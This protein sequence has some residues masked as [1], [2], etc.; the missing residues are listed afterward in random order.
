MIFML[1]SFI[2]SQPDTIYELMIGSRSEQFDIRN[3]LRT[4]SLSQNI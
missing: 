1:M 4:L 3:K 2:E